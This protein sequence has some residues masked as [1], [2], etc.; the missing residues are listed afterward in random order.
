MS[1][2]KENENKSMVHKNLALVKWKKTV[3]ELADWSNQMFLDFCLWLVDK[4]YVTSKE[5][6]CNNAVIEEA[7]NPLRSAHNRC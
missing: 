1:I 3:P 4:N 7:Q 6:L 2:I 5:E